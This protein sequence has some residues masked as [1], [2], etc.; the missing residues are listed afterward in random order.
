MEGSGA[1]GV[2]DSVARRIGTTGGTFASYR[3]MRVLGLAPCCWRRPSRRTTLSVRRPGPVKRRLCSGQHQAS[4]QLEPGKIVALETVADML[5]V[6][7]PGLRERRGAVLSTQTPTV[8]P[9]RLTV[10][11]KSRRVA[12]QAGSGGR[13]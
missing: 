8:S 9:L 11:G 12:V 7:L 5:L 1:L 6:R 2:S 4:L 10:V 3:S 13:T